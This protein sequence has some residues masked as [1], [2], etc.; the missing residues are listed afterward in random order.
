[1][2][3]R[4]LVIVLVCWGAGVSATLGQ[5][6]APLPV[7]LPTVVC[8]DTSDKVRS[9]LARPTAVDFVDTPLHDVVDFLRDYSGIE[10][11]M[12]HL[13][14]AGVDAEAPISL[15]VKELPLEQV[16]R[17]LFDPVGLVAIPRGDVIM[18]TDAGT[19]RSELVLRFYP[20]ID[21]IAAEDAEVSL[22]L[23]KH[24]V[25]WIRESIRPDRWNVNGGPGSIDF[26]PS[27]LSLAVTTDH[28]T[29]AEIA[30]SLDLAREARKAVESWA[31][32]HDVDW[33]ELMEHYVE[34]EPED[35]ASEEQPRPQP[36]SQ[37]PV[38]KRPRGR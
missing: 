11:F 4:Y 32:E 16:I 27:V 15:N 22:R 12:S 17:L 6:K 38:E 20:I 28:A 30:R 13:E 35:D 33:Q 34:E 29:H 24:Q 37:G 10:F 9:G 26:L 3:A 7:R 23:A 19:A 2:S 25:R 5:E 14:D 18:I 1:M 8:S 31:D 36:S 21:L